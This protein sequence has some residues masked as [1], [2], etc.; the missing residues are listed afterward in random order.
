MAEQ[1]LSETGMMVD[2]SYLS[3]I[4]LQAEARWEDMVFDHHIGALEDA[5]AEQ[6][7]LVAWVG[8]LSPY[9][10]MRS[11]SAG[12]CG[13]DYAHHRHFTDYAETWRKELVASLNA[14]FAENAGAEGWE[15]KAGPE[16]WKKAPAFAYVE[17]DAGFA[18]R[19]HAQSI[20]AL[21]VWLALAFGLALRSARRVRVV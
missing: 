2:E 16:L 5:I 3:G 14:A 17:P 7:R 1:G 10:A 8:F 12:L 20:A 11:L 6:E 13:T 9:I 21:V 19:T 15:Y 4:E 18:L